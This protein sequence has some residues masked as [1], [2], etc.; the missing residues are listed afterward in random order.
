MDNK[1]YCLECNRLFKHPKAY[2][3][4]HG[5]NDGRYE[6]KGACQYCGGEY[7]T[8]YV[9]EKCG[10]YILSDYIKLGAGERI[11]EECYTQYYLGDEEYD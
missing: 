9:C 3:E 5:F 10:E 4:T 6:I 7:I 8:A 11:C 2:I 1:Y